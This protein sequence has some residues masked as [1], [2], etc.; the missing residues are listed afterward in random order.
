MAK[1]PMDTMAWLIAGIGFALAFAALAARLY[2]SGQMDLGFLSVSQDAKGQTI[3]ATKKGFFLVDKAEANATFAPLNTTG[4]TAHVTDMAA[5][6]NDL[7]VL[8]ARGQLA[9]CTTASA[10][11]CKSVSLPISGD[12]AKL[13]VSENGAF[14]AITD[15]QGGTLHVL[16]AKTWKLLGSSSKKFGNPNRPVFTADQLFLADN[17]GHAI[18][19]W[20]RTADALRAPNLSVPHT[21]AHKTRNQPYFFEKEDAGY[22]VLEAG[23]MLANAKL[24]RYGNDGKRDVIETGL[25]DAVSMVR[26]PAGSRLLAGMQDQAV[27]EL[28]ATGSAS[29]FGSASVRDVFRKYWETQSVLKNVMKYALWAMVGLFVLPPLILTLLGYNLGEKA[30]SGA[31]PNRLI[32]H[33][34]SE[35]TVEFDPVK[36][37]QDNMRVQIFFSL[38]IVA[39][40]IFIS[41]IFHD[42][43]FLW[44]FAPAVLLAMGVALAFNKRTP[45][46]PSKFSFLPHHLVYEL[47]GEAHHAKYENISIIL[48]QERVVRMFIGDHSFGRIPP[49]VMMWKKTK[50]EENFISLLKT[51][52]PEK[53]IFQSADARGGSACL[54]SRLRI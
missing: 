43:R 15:N 47:D 26:T 9:R 11:Q 24:V 3:L 45:P 7:L 2:A 19:A 40:L 31:E 6:E 50:E 29:P 21:L 54:N 30:G 44:Y 20:P 28:D 8:D 27:V 34:T 35:R 1:K 14:V 18:Q 5:F 48:A 46:S 4:L 13:G 37:K 42:F 49:T 33:K 51:M 38:S 32:G 41:L 12:L 53:Q 17:T 23:S 52:L 16:D 25:A 39:V 10:L 36:I 22:L